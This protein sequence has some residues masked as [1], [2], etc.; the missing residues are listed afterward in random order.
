MMESDESNM[1]PFIGLARPLCEI[2]AENKNLRQHLAYA[3][4]FVAERARKGSG[5]AAG[6]E[7]NIREL[8]DLWNEQCDCEPGTCESKHFVKCRMAWEI[9][10]GIRQ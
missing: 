10:N 2:D 3:L 7:M 4:P 8:L 5:H 1:P 9:E 6:I